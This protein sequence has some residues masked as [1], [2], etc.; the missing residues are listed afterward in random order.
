MSRGARAV[1]RACGALGGRL[2]GDRERGAAVIEFI[3][4]FVTLL[5]PLVYVIGI[6]ADVQRAML[7]TS[8]A[9]READRVYVTSQ[10]EGSA[11]ARA[12]AAYQDVMG[13]FRYQPGDGGATLDLCLGPPGCN[14]TFGPG[15]ELEV[16][17]VYNVPV[18]TLPFLGTV[19]GPT[20]PVGATHHIRIDRF[21]SLIV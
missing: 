11:Q 6:M 5:V 10:D 17:V 21:R 19:A 9:A 3:T 16:R 13:N 8:A 7:A 18:A 20:V 12:T 1:R 4:V 14:G 15:A 2:G